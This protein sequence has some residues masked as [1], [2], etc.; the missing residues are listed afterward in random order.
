MGVQKRGV[1]ETQDNTTRRFKSRRRGEQVETQCDI[2]FGRC[3]ITAQITHHRFPFFCTHCFRLFLVSALATL[4][5]TLLQYLGLVDWYLKF[6]FRA[7]TL[8]G[9]WRGEKR[10]LASWLALACFGWPG[11][12]GGGDAR[13]L[14]RLHSFCT[15]TRQL[16]S[17]WGAAWMCFT[18]GQCVA[19][20]VFL[21]VVFVSFYVP[22]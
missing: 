4:G 11:G 19:A 10:R 22:T 18:L 7:K 2:W 12:S 1:E 5:V 15:A 14:S 17:W 6:L 3:R 16:S 21:C 9:G 13:A 8:L 20:H